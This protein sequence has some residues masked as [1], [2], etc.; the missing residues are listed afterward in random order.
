M[1]PALL[2][3]YFGQGALLLRE[4]GGRREP[5]LFPRAARAARAAG[6][7]GDARRGDR[8]AGADLGRVLAHAAGGAARLLAARDDRAHVAQ[9]GRPD[10][11]PGDQQHADDRLSRARRRVRIVDAL[12][13]AYGI[14]VTGTMAITSLLFAVVARSRWNW[15]LAH[16]LPITVAFLAIDVSLFAANVIKI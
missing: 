5:V 8:V 14:A 2:L 4:S 7:A 16:V 6:R 15:S 9:R 1:L 10:L 12:G 3:N 11:H 13:A